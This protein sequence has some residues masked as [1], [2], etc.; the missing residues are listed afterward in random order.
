MNIF[1]SVISAVSIVTTSATIKK[2]NSFVF[3]DLVYRGEKWDIIYAIP[4]H[5]IIELKK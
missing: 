3:H 4:E 5:E 2:E 1:L